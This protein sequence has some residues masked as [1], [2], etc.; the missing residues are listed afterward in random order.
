MRMRLGTNSF[1]WDNSA[2]LDPDAPRHAHAA[3]IAPR[4]SARK[5]ELTLSAVGAKE[6][7]HRF[8]QIHAL[9]QSNATVCSKERATRI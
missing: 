7:A 2:V 4:T 6:D 5:L 8:T 1:H 3:R 9:G